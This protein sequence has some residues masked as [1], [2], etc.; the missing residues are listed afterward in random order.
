MT[1]PSIFQNK[2]WHLNILL[3]MLIPDA[4]LLQHSHEMKDSNPQITS[5][6]IMIRRGGGCSEY[7]VKK[8]KRTIFEHVFPAHACVL[9]QGLTSTTPLE[10]QNTDRV[11][12]NSIRDVK[13]CGV[14]APP[15]LQLIV[16][17]PC[18]FRTHSDTLIRHIVMFSKSST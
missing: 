9:M 8:I 7:S 18:Q 10:M 15:C 12:F 4:Y 11:S 1:L 2:R 16:T 3:V 6:N 13:N 5:Y 17:A 14:L